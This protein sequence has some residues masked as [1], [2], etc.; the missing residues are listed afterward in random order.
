MQGCPIGINIPGFIR[1]LREGDVKGAYVKIREKNPFPSICG[2]VCSAPCEVACVL[3]DEMSP[4]GIRALERYVSDN[5]KHAIASRREKKSARNQKIAIIGSGP[6]GLAAAYELA[7]E[8]YL[9]TIF[10]ALDQPGGVLRYGIPDFRI[11]RKILE[12]EIQEIRSLSV[13]IKTGFHI[14]QT[15][16][17]NE[18]FMQGYNAIL[19]AMGAGIP[20]F[21]ELPGTHLG[22]VYYGEE[23]LMRTNLIKQKAFGPAEIN[24]YIGQ[25]V[26]VIGSGNTALDCAR[27]AV[28]LGRDVNLIFRR[29][30]DE[31]YIRHEEKEFG[32]EEGVVFE[33]LVKPIEIMG[34]DKNFVSGL[35]CLRVD[36]AEGEQSGKWKL[37]E[38]PNSEFLIETDTV[39]VA[40]GHQPNTLINKTH[41]E[42]E[43][44]VDGTVKIDPDN[45]MTSVPKVFACGNVVTNAGPIVEAIASGQ[46]AALNIHRFFNP[47]HGK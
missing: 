5:G 26:A 11:P 45:F 16:F 19:L 29:T 14:G 47:S 4:I 34:N 37:E 41:S 6:S 43:L 31:M 36:Y 46:K 9:V 40:I 15:L 32:K 38:V 30:E 42:I 25:K 21:M 28:R 1:S 7:L 22:G 23:F 8:G 35:K 18:L 13:D 2:R 24:F 12:A 20:K 10:E 33:P 27:A 39:I 44:N 17:I 3:N